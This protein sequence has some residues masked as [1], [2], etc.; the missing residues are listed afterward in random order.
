MHLTRRNV[1]LGGSSG[2]IAI[3]LPI[4]DIR[5]QEEAID[6]I[7]LLTGHRAVPS[8]RVRLLMPPIF[9]NGYTVPLTLEVDTP[10]TE[11]D[12]V[13]NVRIFAPKNP[14][15][16]VVGFHFA[17][18]RSA[19]R[20]STRIRLAAPQDVIAVAEMNDGAFLMTQTFVQVATN[21]CV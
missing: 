4:R 10:M 18:L 9:P 5:A 20:V 16:E 3:G 2:L 15:N 13:R 1:L 17:P 6:L 7:E 14:I 19:P 11:R 21:G 12:H 8:G